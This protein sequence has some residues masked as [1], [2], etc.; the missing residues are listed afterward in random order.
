M[1]LYQFLRSAAIPADFTR[2]RS[3]T[4]TDVAG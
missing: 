2:L 3:D 1:W 4:S